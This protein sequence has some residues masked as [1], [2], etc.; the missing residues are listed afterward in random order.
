MNTLNNMQGKNIAEP[1][2][3][4]TVG[5]P[6][7]LKKQTEGRSFGV[8]KAVD[9][10]SDSQVKEYQTEYPKGKTPAVPLTK[11]MTPALRGQQTR[12]PMGDMSPRNKSHANRP[13]AKNAPSVFAPYT[14]Q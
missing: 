1:L 12:K 3:M 7:P 5:F 4:K 13:T 2:K 14:N 6:S 11:G 10:E 9:K 8:I